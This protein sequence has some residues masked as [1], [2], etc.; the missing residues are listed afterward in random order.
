MKHLKN[1]L[2]KK[3]IIK[4]AKKYISKNNKGI[5][6]IYHNN[7]HMIN[8][9]NNSKMLFNIYQKKYNLTNNDK[10][11]LVIASL[12][13]DFNHSGGKL[14]DNENIKNALIGLKNF[15]EENE[16]DNYYSN[17][18]NLIECTE[19]PHK[20]IELTVLQKII[21]DADTIS[22]I[23]DGW[24]NIIKNLAEESNIELKEFIPIQ[25]KFLNTIN[26][27]MKYSNDLLKK[28]KKDIIK[29]LNIMIK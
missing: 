13:H 20:K 12:F 7:N 21:R 11:I 15:L 1:Y 17:I 2:Y 3:R 18:K 27:N 4:L 8:V 6:N 26:F 14:T 9:L 22:G 5:K 28:N 19:F 23:R 16:L 29:K 24:E 10:F 25:I